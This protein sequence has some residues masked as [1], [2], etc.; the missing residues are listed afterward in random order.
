MEVN[1]KDKNF[2]NG[3]VM[4]NHISCCGRCGKMYEE[5]LHKIVTGCPDFIEFMKALP[6]EGGE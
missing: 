5:M 2:N 1:T 6:K 4:G 3:F